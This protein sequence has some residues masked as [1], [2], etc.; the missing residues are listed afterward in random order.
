MDTPWHLTAKISNTDSFRGLTD[1][2]SKSQEVSVMFI[3]CEGML[4]YFY[5]MY[6]G[7]GG[8]SLIFILIV[9]KIANEFDH[10][11]HR[12]LV[13]D[14][15]LLIQGGKNQIRSNTYT[16]LFFPNTRVWKIWVWVWDVFPTSVPNINTRIL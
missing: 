14:A 12:N 9:N 2:H 11:D 6:G 15:L 4:L 1:I 16:F 8:A 3:N 7:R 5:Q 13:K 10:K